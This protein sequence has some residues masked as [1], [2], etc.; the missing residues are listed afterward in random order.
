MNKTF[1]YRLL[2]TILLIKKFLLCNR[3][4][5]DRVPFTLYS[6]CNY[7]KIWAYKSNEKGSKV[8]TREIADSIFLLTRLYFCRGCPIRVFRSKYGKGKDRDILIDPATGE[9][10]SIKSL[11]YYFL[12]L[13]DY[14][15]KVFGV[16]IFLLRRS[17]ERTRQQKSKT[18]PKCKYSKMIEPP[19]EVEKDFTATFIEIFVNGEDF[20]SCSV[21]DDVINNSSNS[22]LE[23]RD[24]S[25]RYKACDVILPEGK[26]ECEH[27]K[28]VMAS[29]MRLLLD[30]QVQYEIYLNQEYENTLDTMIKDYK[31]YIQKL[32]K[33]FELL[34]T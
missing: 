4:N 9:K 8:T 3:K 29:M 27:I 25:E 10:I 33:R 32:Y 24:R 13:Q 15:F 2:N 34:R 14:I 18:S 6:L 26:S 31:M 22:T 17:E 11:T 20:W 21:S 23:E 28:G 5:E 1:N 19:R 16:G 7:F 30:W 12:S